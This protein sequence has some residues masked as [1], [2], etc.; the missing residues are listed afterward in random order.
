MS[1]TAQ[2]IFAGALNCIVQSGRYFMRSATVGRRPVCFRAI[3][4]ASAVTA[5]LL[6]P[7]AAWAQAGPPGA[8]EQF[9]L[10]TQVAVAKSF[11][12]GIK[13]ILELWPRFRSRPDFA[14]DR[15]F[16][17]PW[18]AFRIDESNSVWLGAAAILNYPAG[19][20]EQTETRFCSSTWGP[21]RQEI[22]RF[23]P[24][25]ASRSA[26]C[27]MLQA[28]RCACGRAPESKSPSTRTRFG[29]LF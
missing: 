9:Q 4:A 3:L 27:L 6:A 13:G 26:S 24:G 19:R 12:P 10:W 29:R 22:G 2:L 14:L 11:A 7:G 23:R 18:V 17:R 8:V 28:C 16:I 15:F 21:I 5:S 25:C 20:A 1:Q